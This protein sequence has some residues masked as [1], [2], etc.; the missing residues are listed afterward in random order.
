MNKWWNAST[1]MTRGASPLSPPSSSQSRYSDRYGTRHLIWMFQE[2]K[3]SENYVK[4][5]FIKYEKDAVNTTTRVCRKPL[6]RDCD[7]ET[8]EETCTT[9]YEAECVT[10]EVVQ[11]VREK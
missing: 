2:E 7:V 10:K 9:Q 3:C 5:C 1:A 8:N 11:E 6:V 4:D